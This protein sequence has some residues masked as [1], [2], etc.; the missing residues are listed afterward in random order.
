MST[1]SILQ[2]SW[3]HLRTLTANHASPAR[4]QHHPLSYSSTD[5]LTCPRGSWWTNIPGY[6]WGWSRVRRAKSILLHSDCR[7][8]DGGH[9]GWADEPLPAQGGLPVDLQAAVTAH[10]QHQR[11]KN[12]RTEF[13]THASYKKT[14]D[15]V[16][17]MVLDSRD[18]AFLP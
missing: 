6:S 18:Q 17:A 3:P 5:C 2:C 1:V 12:A 16:S 4:N 10:Q 15:K 8:E 7:A 11:G 14:L 13:F 9:P